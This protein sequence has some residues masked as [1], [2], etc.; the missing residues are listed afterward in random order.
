[1][2]KYPTRLWD[3]TVRNFFSCGGQTSQVI[4]PTRGKALS[5]AWACD[6]FEGTSFKRFL[7]YSTCRA[8]ELPE[9]WCT[10]MILN[11]G[12]G[13]ENVFYLGL[14]GSS[15]KLCRA[16]GVVTLAHPYDV[17]PEN[18]R[19]AAYRTQAPP[20]EEVEMTLRAA[21]SYLSGLQT[22]L[23]HSAQRAELAQRLRDLGG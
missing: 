2:T 14:E 5:R 12:R 10:P 11:T 20:R 21:A 15:V 19:P 9:W 23:G 6:A 7:Q 13:P 18:L 22:Q 16:S 17:M 1:M 8:A 3:V 4:A